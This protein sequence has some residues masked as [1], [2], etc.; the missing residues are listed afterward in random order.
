M[1]TSRGSVIVIG[2]VNFDAVVTEIVAAA[3]LTLWDIIVVT[4]YLRGEQEERVTWVKVPAMVVVL[5][6]LNIFK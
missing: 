6:R 4:V 1:V 2:F 5:S 3:S